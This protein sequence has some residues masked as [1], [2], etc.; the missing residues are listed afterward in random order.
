MSLR[1]SLLVAY[2]LAT[3]ASLSAQNSSDRSIRGNDE[4]QNASAYETVVVTGTFT[5]VQETEID[6]SITVI[7]IEGQELLYQNWSEY[8][9]LSP[10]VDFQQRAPGDVQGDLSIRGSTFGQTLVLID[11]LRMN[12]VQTGHHDM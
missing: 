10:S 3:A 12:D 6:R 1:S 9:E 11:G 5:P 4:S 2:I 7:K 8:L